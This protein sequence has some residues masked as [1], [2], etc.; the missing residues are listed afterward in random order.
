MLIVS[1]RT[2][3]CPADELKRHVSPALSSL[4]H[5]RL[6]APSGRKQ[7]HQVGCGSPDDGHS[8]QDVIMLPDDGP[9][10]LHLESINA[11]TVLNLTEAAKI[12]SGESLVAISL[13]FVPV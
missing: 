2:L 3:D 1:Y 10:E 12:V 5:L 7:A 9:A 6:A 11:N 13:Q 4:L 8:G